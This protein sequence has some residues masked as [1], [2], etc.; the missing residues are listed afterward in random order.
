MNFFVDEQSGKIKYTMD[1]SHLFADETKELKSLL[2]LID[3]NIEVEEF[4]ESCKNIDDIIDKTYQND[5]CDIEDLGDLIMLIDNKIT[6]MFISKDNIQKYYD[7]ILLRKKTKKLS[8][9]KFRE[10][11]DFINGENISNGKI[12]KKI[13][14]LDEKPRDYFNVNECEFQH[15]QLIRYVWIPGVEK[16]KSICS[17]YKFDFGLDSNANEDN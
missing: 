7:L 4:E 2:A 12:Q 9:K 13:K 14:Y 5:S 16:L 8:N 1:I 6:Q 15:K 17:K 11:F 3:D 10:G